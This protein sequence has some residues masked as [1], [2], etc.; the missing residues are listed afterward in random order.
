M[1]NAAITEN[2]AGRVLQSQCTQTDLK[3]ALWTPDRLDSPGSLL[4]F[5]QRNM[6]GIQG[7]P[8]MNP[9]IAVTSGPWDLD[10]ATEPGRVGRAYF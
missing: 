9:D 4:P 10:T 3:R 2:G 6:L 7:I 8:P 5:A 1:G